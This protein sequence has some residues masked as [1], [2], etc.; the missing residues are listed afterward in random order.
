MTF[1]Y[2]CSILFYT[3]LY[4]CSICPHVS[5]EQ[6]AGIWRSEQASPGALWHPPPPPQSITLKMVSNILPKS[7]KLVQAVEKL[8]ALP[9]MRLFVL[10]PLICFVSC[11]S[12]RARL[13]VKGSS[14]ASIGNKHG[15][16]KTSAAAYRDVTAISHAYHFLYDKYLGPRRHDE[17]LLLEIG[18]G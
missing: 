13:S 4:D 12:A 9:A 16:D 8:K 14:F 3:F 10:L 5:R 11:E 15:T 1:L 7:R 6:R 17:L 2:D 18:L